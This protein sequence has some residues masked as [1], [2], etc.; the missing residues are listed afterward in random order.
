M[1]TLVQSVVGGYCQGLD[2]VEVVMSSQTVYLCC[3]S[4]MSGFNT[5]FLTLS[6]EPLKKFTQNMDKMLRMLKTSTLYLMVSL[7]YQLM[8]S[9]YFLLLKLIVQLHKKYIY[10]LT[11]L[12]EGLCVGV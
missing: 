5:V 6:R 8:T 3:F 12:P 2:V 7:Y 1:G 10:L 4:L 9:L 11:C